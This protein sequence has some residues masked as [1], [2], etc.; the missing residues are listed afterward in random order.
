[1]N[2]EL[3]KRLEQIPEHEPSRQAKEIAH[4]S[5]D[6][7][8]SIVTRNADDLFPDGLG[9]YNCYAY[10]FDL[11]GHEGYLTIATTS[12]F[13]C[14]PGV[15]ADSEFVQFL[16]RDEKLIERRPSTELPEGV[17]IFFDGDA[18]KHAGKIVCGR[19]TSKWGTGLLFEHEVFEVPLSYGN[20]YK[21]YE[22]TSRDQ[23]INLFYDYAETKGW[24]FEEK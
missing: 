6:F 9:T 11:V 20:A 23:A 5:I 10:A 3:R 7:G 2:V 12:K 21:I 14:P 4:L 19:V 18:P 8:H 24:R 1:M 15:H 17:I 22:S 16:L 13:A